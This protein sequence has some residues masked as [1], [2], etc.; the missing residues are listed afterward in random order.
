MP[1]LSSLPARNPDESE[2]KKELLFIRGIE[3]AGVDSA[4]KF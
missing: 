3:S 2:A 1:S 4:G